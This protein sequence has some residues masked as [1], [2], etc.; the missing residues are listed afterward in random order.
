MTHHLKLFTPGPGDVDEDVLAAAGQP[1]LL[2]YG[3][4]WMEIYNEM[5][6]LLRYFFRTQNDLF[7]VPGPASAA[8]DMA[9]GS[10]LETGQKMILGSN[11]FFGER[12][13]E[14]ARGYGIEA[15]PFTAPLGCPLDPNLLHCLLRENTDAKVVALVHHETSTTVLNPLRE[16]AETVR[17]AGRVCLVDAVSSL[18]GVE[19]DVDGWGIDVCVTSS[20]KCFES[21]PGVAF[22]SVS[23]HAWEQIDRAASS[24]HG[25]YLNLRTWRKYQQEW[26]AWHPSPVTLPVNVILAALVSMRKIAKAGREAHFA[27][28]VAASQ[29]VRGGLEELGF[30]MFVP[31]AFAAPIATAVKA[32]PEFE[33]AG[34]SQWLS[35]QR[36]IAISGGLGSLAGKIFRVGHLGKA[37]EMENISEFLAAVEE[38]LRSRK[39]AVS[40]LA[41]MTRQG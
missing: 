40:P 16:M 2:H 31:T 8:I 38:F 26:G 4:E 35:S 25:W 23:P 6:E 24:G 20:N 9:I 7:I 5:L 33:V 13:G 21:L 3:P 36:G 19:L 22:I 39:I 1:M 10:L 15:V 18:G 12:L 32:R 41:R 17:E 37:A 11:G 14:I 30:E 28:Y 29:A 27:R 34:L